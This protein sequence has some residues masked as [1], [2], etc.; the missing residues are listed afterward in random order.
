MQYR[1]EM[2]PKGP[3]SP[4]YVNFLVPEVAPMGLTGR[5]PIAANQPRG[6]LRRLN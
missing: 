5:P 3:I 6:F 4:C 2:G 1:T